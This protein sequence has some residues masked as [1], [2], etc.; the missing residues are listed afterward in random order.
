MRPVIIYPPTID[1]D[2]LHQRPQQLLRALSR[3]GAVAVFCNLNLHQKHSAGIEA[4]TQTLLL[5][6]DMSLAQTLQW[7]RDTY[8]QSP[9][10][11]YFTY[12]PQSSFI[13]QLHADL[14]IFDSVDEPAGEFAGWRSGYQAAT[15]TSDIVL[16]S[17]A[18]LFD[19]ARQSTGKPVYLLPNGCDFEHFKA[20]QQR[21][22][23]KEEPFS[24]DK[25]IIGYI[26]AIAPWVDWRLVNSMAHYLPDYEFV[27]I[28]APLL[29]S[30]VGFAN[31]NMHY[32]GHKDY[33]LLPGYL[34]NFSYCLIPFKIT[35]MTKSINPVKFW[36]YL[37]S[38]IPILAT[39]LPEI[40]ANSAIL[41]S[42]EMFP[43]F[44]PEP[45]I[46]RSAERIHLAEANS[47]N[48]RAEQL[49]VIIQ[50]RLEQG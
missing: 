14:L 1:W 44:Y 24:L 17:A 38:G 46:A 37:A 34:S 33:S 5:A 3:Y 8:P 41:I 13:S 2:Q 29:Q 11:I 9:A 28:G 4:V 22:C 27:F 43:G 23:L 50:T 19:R 45:N 31:K 35:E 36:E 49:L 26:G 40:P 6:N 48:I 47:W 12:P 15:N 30:G 21:H 42:E 20:A 32:L 25:P 39:P 16:A 10:V 18:A 7:V